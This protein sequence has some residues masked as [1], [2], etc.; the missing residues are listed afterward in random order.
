MGEGC[1]GPVVLAILITAALILGFLGL[2][3]WQGWSS[4]YYRC[5]CETPTQP[6]ACSKCSAECPLVANW[7]VIPKALHTEGLVSQIRDTATDTPERA[8]A[9]V[10]ERLGVLRGETQCKQAILVYPNPP[11]SQPNFYY[12]LG[13]ASEAVTDEGWNMYVF[14]T[15]EPDVKVRAQ[16]IPT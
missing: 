5:H 13:I 8:E 7:Y 16:A 14:S 11:D 12:G 1:A 15:V 3:Q 4:P 9:W 6:G 10:L 2:C